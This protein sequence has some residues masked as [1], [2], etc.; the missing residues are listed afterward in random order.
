MT[1]SARRTLGLVFIIVPPVS[2]VASLV[3]WTLFAFL[4]PLMVLSGG[5]GSMM[6]GRLVNIVLG[7]VGMLG[8]IGLFIAFPIG[9]YLFFSTPKP[10]GA[11]PTSVTPPQV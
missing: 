7:F 11:P 9:L 5:G 6:V 8:V 1:P 2:L 10:A 3:L 4:Y